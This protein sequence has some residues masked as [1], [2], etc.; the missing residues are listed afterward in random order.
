MKAIILAA[1]LGTRMG[2]L[3]KDMPKPLL[4][5]KN[6][7][8]LEHNLNALKDLVDEII[9]VVGY[10]KEKIM[11]FLGM[12]YN[13]I[14]ITYVVQKEQK[15]TGDALIAVN[16][17]NTEILKNRFILLMG[18]DIYSKEDIENCLKYDNAIL[19]QK[20]KDSSRFGVY[21]VED[22]LI[23]DMVEKPK[24]FVSEL[25][26]AALYVFDGVELQYMQVSERGEIEF[27]DVV[28]KIVKERDVHC[29]L[30]KRWISIAT[31]EDLERAERLL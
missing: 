20:V 12:N 26:N 5:V 22:G 3:T 6:K 19:T 11:E 21:I 7:T 18:D 15:G 25:A 27:T 28:K 23:K 10:K 30:A 17:F 14:K 29:V 1:G 2:E 16:G 31:P 4:K 13:G 9:I 24:E 8:L